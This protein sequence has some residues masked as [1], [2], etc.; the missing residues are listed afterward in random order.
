M[1]IDEIS[2]IDLTML[3]VVNNY[4]MTARSIDRSSPNLFGGLPVVILIVDFF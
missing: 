4:C 1:F 3:S 2:I